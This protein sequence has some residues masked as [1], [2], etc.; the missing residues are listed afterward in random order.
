MESPGIFK[1]E[2]YSFIVISPLMVLLTVAFIVNGGYIGGSIC[3]VLGVLSAFSY[4]GIIIDTSTQRY[5]KYDRFLKFRIGGWKDLP[6]PSYVTVVRINISSRRTAP[7]PIVVPQD[8]KG[9]RAF[10][11]NLVVEGQMRYIGICRGSLENMTKE[12]LRL[13]EHL[14]LRVL[15][16]TTHEKKW[17]L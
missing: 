4:Q 13:G 16:Y 10:K 15:D 17:I 14:Q 1:Y 9:A 11:V 5:M 6:V 12:A 8:K 3:F 7:T 2:K